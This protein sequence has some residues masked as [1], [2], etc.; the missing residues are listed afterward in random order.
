MTR[1]DKD[2]NSIRRHIE[3]FKAWVKW[4]PGVYV[5]VFYYHEELLLAAAAFLA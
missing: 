3:E 4:H 2:D 5:C 1:E